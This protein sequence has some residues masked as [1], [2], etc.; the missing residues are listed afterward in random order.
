ML[1]QILHK[2]FSVLISLL[3]LFS[4]VSFT[5]EKHFC[6]DVLVDV[7][8]FTEAEKCAM[9][10]N[11]KEIETITKKTCCKDT[12]DVFEGQDELIV[13]TLDDLDLKQQL[14]VASYIYSYINLFEGL[15]QQV[16]PHKNYFPPNLVFDIQVLDQVFLI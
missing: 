9:E 2:S 14:F 13:K 6:G 3:V 4:T 15:P 7:S 1:K 12:V 11:E 8:V 5:V 10:V 16:I